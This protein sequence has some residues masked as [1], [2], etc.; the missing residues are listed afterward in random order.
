MMHTLGFY[1][2]HSRSDR[3]MYIDIKW[4]NIDPIYHPQFTT[5]RQGL[6]QRIFADKDSG[7]QHYQLTG[8]GSRS[9]GLRTRVPTL[10][11]FRQGFQ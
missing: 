3:D 9:A 10:S 2:E 8:K 7:F 6:Q 5:Y 4:N 11:A 1:H